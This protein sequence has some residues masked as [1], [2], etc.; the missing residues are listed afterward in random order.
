[1]KMRSPVDLQFASIEEIAPSPEAVLRQTMCLGVGQ[2]T[3]STPRHRLD[4]HRPES[5]NRLRTHA[6]GQSNAPLATTL[7]SFLKQNFGLYWLGFCGAQRFPPTGERR[8]V[9]RC[10]AQ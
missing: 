7:A 5:L 1:M 6:N 3:Y 8:S 2:C 9:S 10:C 4:M